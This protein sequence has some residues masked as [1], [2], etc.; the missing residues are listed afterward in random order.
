M[1]PKEAS[2]SAGRAT[3]GKAGRTRWRPSVPACGAGCCGSRPG[4]GAIRVLFGD[5]SEALTHP[6]L[7]HAAPG[8]PSRSWPLAEP[9]RA[10]CAR[11]ARRGADLRVAAPGQA[12]RR[13]LLRA[14]AAATGRL[15][16]ETST[17]Q[18]SADF[19]GLLERL[20]R[21]FAP[22]AG[23]PAKPTVLVLDTARPR[24]GGGPIHT[25]PRH[26][27][28]LAARPWRTTAWLPTYAPELNDCERSWR[29]LKR[30]HRAHRTFTSVDHRNT[31]IHHAVAAI[32]H[33]RIA[34]ACPECTNSGLADAMQ[35]VASKGVRWQA[36]PAASR[37]APDAVAL[38]LRGR[39]GEGLRCSRAG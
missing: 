31:Q 17:S 27:Q 6:Y 26:R 30:H 38:A 34:N 19:I 36:L 25:Q 4:P 35:H 29:D 39:L 22:P 23:A 37:C 2:P 28:A 8:P 10:R 12:R 1:R 3:A 24:S 20:D 33:E 18:R 7:A 11:S 16:V 13:A 32:N 5:Q 21:A 14:L 9:D 15:I